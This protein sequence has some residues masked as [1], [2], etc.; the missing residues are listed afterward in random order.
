MAAPVPRFGILFS[1]FLAVLTVAVLTAVLNLI[2]MFA[3]VW[4]FQLDK[5]FGGGVFNI[6]V[7]FQIFLLLILFAGFFSALLL[8]VTSFAKSF[9]EAQVYLIPIILL[10]L[11]PGLMAMAPGMSLDGVYAVVPM[12]NI[13]LLARDVI[14]GQVMPVPAT[15][16]VVSTL[17][18]SYLAIRAAAGIFGSDGILNAGSGNFAE[19]FHRPAKT[20]YVVPIFATLFCLIL[21]FPIN[22]ASI[23][24]LGRLPSETTAEFSSSDFRGRG[25]VDWNQPLDSCHV[26]D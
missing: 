13:L 15:I 22:F 12:M 7:M 21:L 24:F 6:T 23:G 26:V 9:K 16:A 1:K 4:A 20:T 2:G 8:V 19:M 25:C 5:Q 3:T 14:M 10:S 18:Y 17:L 11:G